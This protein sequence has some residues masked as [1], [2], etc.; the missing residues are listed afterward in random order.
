MKFE[1]HSVACDV[2][3]LENKTRSKNPQV[4]EIEDEKDTGG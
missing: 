3:D 4:L 1:F 2:I